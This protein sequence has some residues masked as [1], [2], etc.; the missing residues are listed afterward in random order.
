MEGVSNVWE[1]TLP[2]AQWQGKPLLIAHCSILPG[3]GTPIYEVVV[4]SVES[5]AQAALLN[6]KLDDGRLVMEP[7]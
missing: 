5:A 7:T 3:M 1:I 6:R 4:G 2:L